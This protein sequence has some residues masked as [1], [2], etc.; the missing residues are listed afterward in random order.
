M[1]NFVPN[2]FVM[3]VMLCK[4]E[5]KIPV[6][7]SLRPSKKLLIFSASECKNWRDLSCRH[8]N[9]FHEKD[10]KWREIREE[11]KYEKNKKSSLQELRKSILEQR[12]K[13]KLKN[14][15]EIEVD[16]DVQIVESP[17]PMTIEELQAKM[18]KIDEIKKIKEQERLAEKQSEK[19]RSFL[20]HFF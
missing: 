14:N 16:D 6:P 18:A 1:K 10:G 20:F 12:K 3:S 11:I 2:A 15:E 8:C 7:T 13:K 5:I 19:L 9:A 17:T 4:F